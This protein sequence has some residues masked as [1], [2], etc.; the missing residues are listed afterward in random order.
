VAEER[1]FLDHLGRCEECRSAVAGLERELAWLPM[2]TRPVRP[3]PGL[4]RQI[5]QQ[6]LG[7]FRPRRSRWLLPRAV[8]AAAVLVVAVFH[9]DRREAQEL[10]GVLSERSAELA[11]LRDSLS[12][13]QQA[14]RVLQAQILMDGHE[15]GMLIFADTVSHRWNVVVHGL[16]PA[17][18]GETYQFW[19]I[20]AD[21]MVRGA[22]VTSDPSRP[23]FFTL[24]MPKEGG[25]VMGA[26]LTMEPMNN[27]SA[28]PRGKELAHLML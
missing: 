16:P 9:P 23:A 8:A 5:V 11:A 27:Q 22:T 15:G 14:A 1:S 7:E 18:P 2:G 20:A 10:R 28:E 21:G 25:E 17:P 12:V 6:V 13:M 19:F 26:A 3:R 24:E 4:R